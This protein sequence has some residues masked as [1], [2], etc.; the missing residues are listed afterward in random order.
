MN[1]AFVYAADVTSLKD[2][3][4]DINYRMY[5]ISAAVVEGCAD[6]KIP[7]P[8]LDA[9]RN[10]RP[11]FPPTLDVISPQKLTASVDA[12]F[13]LSAKDFASTVKQLIRAGISPRKI[14]PWH[15][16]TVEPLS[17]T[18]RDGT[19]LVCFEGLE[20]HVKNLR[21]KNFVDQTIFRLSNQKQLRHKPLDELPKLL[22]ERYFS[23]M[24]RP[25]DLD[26][27]K[28]FTEKLNWLKLYDLSPLKTRLADKVAV[29][30]FVAEKIGA[31]HLIDSLGVWDDFDAIDFDA[32]PAQFV[33]KCNH[34]SGMN[35]VVADKNSL[36][37]QA[38]RERFAAWLA[39]DYSATQ[40]ELHY[41]AI[42]RK[43]LAEKFIGAAE[44][45][46]DDYKVHCFNGAAKFIQVLGKTN[47]A[48]GTRYHEVLSFDGKHLN[49]PPF[50]RQN[51]FPT[52]PEGLK[53]LSEFKTCAEVLSKGFAYVRADFYF[54]DG[55]IF[56]GEMTFCHEAGFTPYD[57]FWTYARDLA[58]GAQ[59]ELRS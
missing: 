20:F 38:A 39:T 5:D 42:E 50:A 51:F 43:I 58:L 57:D 13:I 9:V 1:S 56:F 10:L 59:I 22:Q 8:D 32:L 15:A 48:T 55:R 2:F 26:A 46:L 52:P 40:F 14:I 28:T 30:E 45:E 21:D 4:T 11:N 12:V 16:T 41:G 23:V 18:L 25:L 3:L 24:G 35:V 31:Q 36:D 6:E 33:L 29:R 49:P 44:S 19:Q 34:G 47:P 53:H 54:V 7:V 37:V 17:F 27:P